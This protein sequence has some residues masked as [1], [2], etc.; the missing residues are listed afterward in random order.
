VAASS[1]ERV[2]LLLV[3]LVSFGCSAGVGEGDVVGNVWAP[4]CGLAGDAYEMR[5]NFFSADPTHD[6]LD[7]RVQRGSDFEDVSDGMAV[8]VRAASEVAAILGTPIALED[9]LE[10]PRAQPDERPLVAMSVYL[11]RTCPIGAHRFP[12][13]YQAV[14]GEITF[15]AIYAPELP[16][17]ALEVTA[18][19]S[20][21]RFVDP[22]T[23]ETRYAILS[24]NFSFIFNRGRPAQR[25]P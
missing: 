16:G 4:A 9:P 19:F 12:V 10:L 23:P 25:F 15:T 21:V 6:F 11:N 14:T 1:F 17:S 18:A 13:A 22:S 3:L 7:I 24:G 2:S 5:S 8:S 20:D